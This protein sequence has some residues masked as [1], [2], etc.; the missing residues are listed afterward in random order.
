MASALGQIV[1]EMVRGGGGYGVP[2]TTV[3]VD[4]AGGDKGDVVWGRLITEAQA[5]DVLI[6]TD[7]HWLH[8]LNVVD[9]KLRGAVVDDMRK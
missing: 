2:T 9:R 7:D 6:M 8:R 3:S 1:M 4:R 5:G